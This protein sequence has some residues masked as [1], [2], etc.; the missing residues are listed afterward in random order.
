[1]SPRTNRISSHPAK[2]SGTIA[3]VTAMAL[4]LLV[5]AFDQ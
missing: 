2:A 5:E 3:M 4:F 1:M